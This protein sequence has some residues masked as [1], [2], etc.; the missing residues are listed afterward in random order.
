MRI[1]GLEPTRCYPLAPQASAYAN[2]AIS[3]Y[4]TLSDI[5]TI[6][7]TLRLETSLLGNGGI[8]PFRLCGA[9]ERNRTSK[10]EF[11]RLVPMPV[12][13]RRHG[14]RHSVHDALT[15]REDSTGD[16][17]FI[18]QESVR[19]L[20]L[21]FNLPLSH[22]RSGGSTFELSCGNFSMLTIVGL[23]TYPHPWSLR[24]LHPTAAWSGRVDSNHRL[25]AYQTSALTD[26]TTSRCSGRSRLFFVFLFANF[27]Y[28]LYHIFERKSKIHQSNSHQYS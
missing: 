4:N 18:Y 17:K 12:R 27:L 2:S 22:Q 25:L 28:I 26:C 9:G 10:T 7:A 14:C 15:S 3:A 1:E 20:S 5:S 6:R 16:R 24:G 8:E 13:L 21:N 11:L 23:P 19:V